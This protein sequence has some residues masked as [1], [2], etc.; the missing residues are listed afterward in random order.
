[1]NNELIAILQ[2]EF[3][4]IA[5]QIDDIDIEFWYARKLQKVLG[6]G[7][8]VDDSGFGRIR[9]KGDNALFGG[10]NTG[11]MKYKLNILKGR[12]LADFL[13]TVT[14]TA[15]NLA[16]EITNHNLKQNNLQGEAAITWE[17]VQNN[18]SVRNVLVERG[19]KPEEL[20]VSEE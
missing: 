18:S 3:N 20:P 5:H 7:C 2:S 1:M 6:Y 10:N 13:S 4:S 12:L 19:I 14:I 9:S 17:H 11:Q 8:G 16:T 15:K